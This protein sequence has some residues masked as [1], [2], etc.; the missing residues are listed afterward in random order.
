MRRLG[1]G[2]AQIRLL[3]ENDAN[4]MNTSLMA[5]LLVNHLE[6]LRARQAEVAKQIEE[7]S[8]ILLQCRTEKADSF[9]ISQRRTA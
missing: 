3:I 2:I 6:T 1:M 7:T 5:N 4:T 8:S 9:Q